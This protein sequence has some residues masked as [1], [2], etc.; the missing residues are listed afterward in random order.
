MSALER[1][2]VRNFGG[3]RAVFMRRAD[4]AKL[5]SDRDL[6]STQLPA[7]WI[8]LFVHLEHIRRLR[9]RLAAVDP[10]RQH[11]ALK[12][13]DP[14]TVCIRISLQLH[15]E[16]VC[17]SFREDTLDNNLATIPVGDG[18]SCGRKVASRRRQLDAWIVVANKET[19]LL[20]RLLG[21]RLEMGNS[22][23][24]SCERT[25]CRR[26]SAQR[27][28]PI[29]EACG[30]RIAPRGVNRRNIRDGNGDERA[31]R[32]RSQ[33]AEKRHPARKSHSWAIAHHTVSRTYAERRVA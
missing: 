3:E 20:S 27:S 10:A 18:E 5:Y 33:Q 11:C 14:S 7:V 28:D 15:R 31:Y 16:N 4:D 1:Q 29:S 12:R 26:P 2:E 19:R 24:S 21:L 6:G 13:T 8:T 30:A 23:K 25:C 17:P 9:W 22:K 32:H